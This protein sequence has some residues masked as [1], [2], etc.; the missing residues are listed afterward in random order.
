MAGDWWTVLLV[1]VGTWALAAVV[2]LALDV[3]RLWVRYRRR[4]DRVTAAVQR[5]LAQRQRERA[6]WAQLDAEQRRR[7]RAVAQTGSRTEHLD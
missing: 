2:F 4:E 7:L 1:A 6:M 5:D 3:G